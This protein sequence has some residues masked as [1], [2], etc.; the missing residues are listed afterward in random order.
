MLSNSEISAGSGRLTANK[1]KVSDQETLVTVFRLYLKQ[2]VAEFSDLAARLNAVQDTSDVKTAAK[3]AAILISLE[4]NGFDLSELR[5]GRS[6][7]VTNEVGALVLKIRFGLALL[8]YDLPEQFSGA[9]ENVDETIVGNA[10]MLGSFTID[11]KAV[12]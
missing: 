7:L 8:G 11:K 4:E 6:G 5:G 12:W 2:R 9:I 10:L 1:L 3:L